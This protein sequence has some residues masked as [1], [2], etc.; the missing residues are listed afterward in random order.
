[1]LNRRYKG[2]DIIK[3]PG[4]EKIFYTMKNKRSIRITNSRKLEPMIM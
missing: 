2:G 3:E 4:K 1:M